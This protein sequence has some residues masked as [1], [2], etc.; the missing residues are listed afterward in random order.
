VR[1][2]NVGEKGIMHPTVRKAE[3]RNINWAEVASRARADVGDE[4]VERASARLRI[5]MLAVAD[6]A[7]PVSAWGQRDRERASNTASNT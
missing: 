6:S 1:L 4:R 3:L 5:A 2:W 7:R